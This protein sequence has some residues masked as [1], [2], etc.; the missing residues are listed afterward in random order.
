[1]LKQVDEKD[2]KRNR[3]DEMFGIVVELYEKF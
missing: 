2:A 3:E 1:M